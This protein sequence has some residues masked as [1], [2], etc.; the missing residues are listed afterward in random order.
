MPSDRDTPYN[1]LPDL[2][3]PVEIET[4]A[5]LREAIR[6]NRLLA[7]LK[8]YC[9]TLPN[10][11]LLLNTVVLQESKDSSAIEN[12]V[13]TQDELYRAVAAP[14]DPRQATPEAKEVLRYR[15]AV[16]TGM[17]ELE[18]T[19]AITT[20]LLIRIMQTLK[21]TTA[22]VRRVPGTKLAN[23]FTKDVIYTPPEGEGLLRDKLYALER[24]INEESREL[25]PLVT[26][27]LAHYQF[28]AIHPFADGNGRTGRILN[29]LYLVQQDLLTLPVLYL[30]GYVIQHK[31]DYYRLLRQVTEAGAWH[32]WVL[33]MLRAVA[34]TSQTTL[35]KIRQ[36]QALLTETL[37]TAR[38][39]L[40]RA[41]AR[42][43]VDLMFSYPYLRIR[44]LEEAG[45]AK[46]QAASKYLN[47]LA[48]A[49]LL[50]PVKLGRDVYFI[51]HA[52]MRLFVEPEPQ[53][54]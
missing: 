10:P 26:T 46:R 20:N 35:D 31:R 4:G 54:G 5:V 22:D 43:I 28:E 23:P 34:E 29:V 17:R 14:D 37:E 30:S 18:R 9:Q 49:G 51:N 12:I 53:P 19:G 41:P 45:I 7:E 50:Q 48:D 24:F 42:E 2:P 21:E 8:G 36:M 3:P 6:A 16:Y 40:S 33:Y 1:D 52:L 11:E 27:A 25:D 39:T 15:E 32:E 47:A 38:D 44:M 13:T